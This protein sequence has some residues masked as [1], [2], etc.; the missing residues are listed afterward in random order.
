MTSIPVCVLRQQA[1]NVLPPS[2]PLVDWY[3]QKHHSICM[4]QSLKKKADTCHKGKW[5]IKHQLNHHLGA[6][7]WEVQ[8]PTRRKKS[9]Q[10][11]SPWHSQSCPRWTGTRLQHFPSL[12]SLSI[13]PWLTAMPTKSSWCR[14][15]PQLGPHMTSGTD[16][17]SG[18]TGSETYINNVM[19]LPRTGFSSTGY[20]ELAAEAI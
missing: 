13:H 18:N 20:I 14:V 2:V 1:M 4:F 16:N 8:L 12:S 9:K 15:H 7:D 11:C 10:A 5:K 6:R 3:T 17:S 19:T